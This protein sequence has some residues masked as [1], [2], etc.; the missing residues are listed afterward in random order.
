MGLAEIAPPIKAPLGSV[1]TDRLHLRP[2]E[3]DDLDGLAT[4]FAK[5]AVW[6]FPYGR[7]FT[8]DETAGFIESQIHGWNELGFGC[9]IATLLGTDEI[10]GFV[11]LSVPRFLPAI[12]PAVEVGWRFDPDHWGKGF[13]TEGALAGLRE[14]FATLGLTEICSLPQ[15]ANPRS[16]AVCERLGMTFE[17]TITCPPTDRRGEVEAR[18]YT[19]SRDG[20]TSLA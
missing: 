6:Q 9:W 20:W 14:G 4:V 18:K 12:L 1:T 7:G 3:R 19:M 11:G 16:F 5:P 15:S 17:Q 13:A 10:V 8:R 2:F